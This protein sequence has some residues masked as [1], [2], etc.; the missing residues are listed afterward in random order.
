MEERE[1]VK[2]N[3]AVMLAE[4]PSNFPTPEGQEVVYSILQRLEERIARDWFEGTLQD[5]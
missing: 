5:K 1:R 2:E 3:I 4:E